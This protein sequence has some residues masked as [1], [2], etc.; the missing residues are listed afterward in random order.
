[1]D[2]ADV[3]GV[4]SVAS[5]IE[6]SGKTKFIIRRA[7]SKSAPLWE[8]SGDSKQPNKTKQEFVNWANT[9]LSSGRNTNLYQ[10]SLFNDTDDEES[11]AKKTKEKPFIFT[12][13]LS[14]EVGSYAGEGPTVTPTKSEITNDNLIN[15]VRLV[16]KEQ[17]ESEISKRLSDIEN[18]LEEEDE[19]FLNGEPE[20]K[21][22]T[23]KMLLGTLAGLLAPKGNA[24]QMQGLAGTPTENEKELLRNAINRLYKIDK[25]L[26]NDLNK[27]ADIGEN[28]PSQFKFLLNALRNM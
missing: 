6:S 15:A 23:M 2:N 24:G 4:N 26:P 21:D 12:F 17:Q 7:G 10:I 18:K 22:D 1:M 11:T 20:E 25:D 5:L 3:Y 16:M 28:N 13:A 27:L 8:Y 14:K 9:L 19:E